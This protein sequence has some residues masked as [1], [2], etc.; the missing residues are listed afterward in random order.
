MAHNSANTSSVVDVPLSGGLA[1]SLL[2]GAVSNRW[3]E[4]LPYGSKFLL[5]YLMLLVFLFYFNALLS[6][7]ALNPT[8][9]MQCDWRH[10]IVVIT[11]GSGGIGRALVESFERLGTTAILDISPPSYKTSKPETVSNSMTW[12]Q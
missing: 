2:L 11:G 6:R 7:N 4:F 8:G 9:K 10:E 5:R 12:C 3:L 1:M